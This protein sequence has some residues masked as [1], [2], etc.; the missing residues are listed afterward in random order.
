M[1]EDVE[2]R[3]L[4]PREIKRGDGRRG[5]TFAYIDRDLVVIPLNEGETWMLHGPGGILIL[6][7]SRKPMWCR[8]EN[9]RYVRTRLEPN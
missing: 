5:V 9:G 8:M 7:P 6:H 2:I 4:Q 3:M 1:F